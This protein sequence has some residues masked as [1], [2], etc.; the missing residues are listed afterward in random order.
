MTLVEDMKKRVIES[1]KSKDE[2]TR[3]VLRVAISD[4][5][6]AANTKEQGGKPLTDGQIQKI[7]ANII[8]GNTET[9]QYATGAMKEKLEKENQILEAYIPKTASVAEITEKLE[10]LK[11]KIL[12]AKSSG[13]ATGIAVKYLKE[14]GLTADGNDVRA[15][16]EQIRT[17]Q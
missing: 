9:L 7:I 8:K 11:P 13:Q 17:I 10:S 15:V 4:I 5:D 6:A 14:Q 2:V 12:E 3:D 16:V 1:M